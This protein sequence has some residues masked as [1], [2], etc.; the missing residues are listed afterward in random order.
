MACDTACSCTI[1]LGSEIPKPQLQ[2]EHLAR[3]VRSLSVVHRRAT[4]K[5]HRSSSRLSFDKV[6][7]M[8]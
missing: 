7:D 4:M 5:R 1:I 2:A 3:D 8:S 6:P